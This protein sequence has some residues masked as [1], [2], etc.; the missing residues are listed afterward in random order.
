MANAE[1]SVGE[2]EKRDSKDVVDE[3][4][5]DTGTE[6]KKAKLQD[7]SSSSCSA[8]K[9]AEETVTVNEEADGG[10]APQAPQAP[11]VEMQPAKGE[12]D[13][14][15]E[16][17]CRYCFEG[18][19]GGELI[20]PCNCGGSQ[21]Y[22]HLQ[23]LRRW[24]RMVLV[25][26]PTHPSFYERDARH[27]T[28]NVCKADFKCAPPT[29]HELM[30]SF[31][32]GEI[33]ALID[34]NC[35]IAAHAVFS[36]ELER[37]IQ[38]LPVI[39][40]GVSN[41]DHW[42]RGVYLIT[43]V[44]EDDGIL[45]VPISSETTL[46]TLRERIGDDM[47]ITIR[48]KRFRVAAEGALAGVPASGLRDAFLALSVPTSLVL[49]PEEPSNCGEDHIAAVNL[50][51]PMATPPHPSEVR[52][53][54]ARYPA[55]AKV[56][57][58]HYNGGPCD[59]NSIV[60]CVVPGGT[61]KGWTAVEGLEEALRLAHSRA[62]RR[63]EAQGDFGGGQTVKLKGLQ[64]R[65][66]LNDEIGLALRFLESTGR[67]LVRLRNGEGKQLKPT[68][69]EGLEG[70]DGRVCVFWGDARWSRVQLLGEIAR[71]HWGLCHASISE[72]VNPIPERRAGLEGRL[73]FAPETEMTEDFMKQ[74][75]RQMVALRALH[76]AQGPENRPGAADDSDEETRE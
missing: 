37:Q 20:S 57:I 33:A 71:G 48:G 40:R 67:W 66:D 2:A 30:S 4:M 73:V 55:A 41:Y 52:E 47:A 38:E 28:C 12:E 1:N 61:G 10:S 24:Q 44:E 16:R 75:Q 9:Q 22:V 51:R 76:N 11:D 13:D 8:A 53:A 32:G 68:N 42:I 18:T 31:T 19:E 70:K 23:C 69:L 62:A 36:E 50:T 21:K 7:G 58:V 34:A 29:R 49:V 59:A 17:L 6:A 45:K 5:R 15:E 65:A 74:G 72:I 63:C 54:R 27:H 3:G 26:Q 35:I 46:E 25:S 43:N 64:S 14:E 60:R 56:E 39:A